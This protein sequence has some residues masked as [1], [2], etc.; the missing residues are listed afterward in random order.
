MVKEVEK[1]WNYVLF[2]GRHH[3]LTQY[4]ADWIQ[5]CKAGKIKDSQGN[6]IKISEDTKWI[7]VITSANH[8]T[9]RR[10]PVAIA[11]RIAQVELFGKQEGIEILISNISDVADSLRFA[12][13]VIA[14]VHVDLGIILSTENTLVAVSTPIGQQYKT[15]GYGLGLIEKDSLVE[16]KTPWQLVEDIVYGDGELF[17]LYAHDAS[18]N[19]WVR[20]GL[21]SQ[22]KQVFEDGVVSNE[23][24][25]LTDTREYNTYAQAFEDSAKR[26]WSQIKDWVI[27]GRIVDIGSATGQL[28][29]EAGLEERLSQS[30][31]IGIEPDRWL[32]AQSI[33]RAEQ[34]DFSN[35]NTFFY[36]KNILNG[37]VFQVNSVDTTITA[38]LTH[39]IYSYGDGDNDLRKIVKIIAHH[40][41]SGGVWINL[42]VCG[43]SNGEQVIHLRLRQDDGVDLEVVEDIKTLSNTEISQRLFTASTWVRFKQ[44]NNDWPLFG[45]KTSWSTKILEPGL[46]EL[47]LK[48]AMEYML[49]KDYADNWISELYES[50]TYRDW[51]SW[52][53]L[54]EEEGMSVVPGSGLY[55]NDWIVENRFNTVAELLDSHGN[56]LPW[57]ATHMCLVASKN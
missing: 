6:V 37:D 45:K 23:D 46:V 52:I 47:S 50:F 26:K 18:K 31:L 39:E 22:V 10:N 14:S 32:H 57:P 17:S 35:V 44:F 16:V 34:G 53:T 30:D 20:Y 7:F 38:A 25:A 19:V 24:G 33:H 4:Q 21:F 13:H 40:T 27:P 3:A 54:L 11:R 36:R 9:T 41:R 48:N 5:D 1:N 55:L 2:P 15:L 43:P 51:T 29:I 28:L 12:E 42:D 8:H 56:K 49:H